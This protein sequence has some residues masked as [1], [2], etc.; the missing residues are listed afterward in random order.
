M[1]LSVS[2]TEFN[3]ERNPKMKRAMFMSMMNLVTSEDNMNGLN[4]DD[5]RNQEE[6][7]SRSAPSGDFGD[8]VSPGTYGGRGRRGGRGGRGRGG[9]G[10]RGRGRGTKFVYPG[11]YRNNGVQKSE[12]VNTKSSEFVNLGSS[13]KSSKSKVEF[14]NTKPEF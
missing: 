3:P 5:S 10:G 7:D 12:F 1:G 2:R 9:R 14:V 4:H 6:M 11:E 13:S 8:F